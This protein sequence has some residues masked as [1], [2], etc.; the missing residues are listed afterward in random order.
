M[1]VSPLT[2]ERALRTIDALPPVRPDVV[3]A[4]SARR[5]AGE[6]PS[7]EAVADRALVEVAALGASC[8]LPG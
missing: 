5:A 3:A 8:D 7:A 2:L 6:R 1:A 4:V